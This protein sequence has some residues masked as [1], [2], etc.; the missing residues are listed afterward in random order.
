MQQVLV[1]DNPLSQ[2]G[3]HVAFWPRGKLRQQREHLLAVLD[4][5]QRVVDSH[6]CI[7][8]ASCKAVHKV[9]QADMPRPMNANA[10]LLDQV[11][12]FG[13]CSISAVI[14]Q[15]SAM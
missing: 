9:I 8:L 15:L 1:E 3:G 13:L 5:P 4:D 14:G 6:C 11:S 7:A 12:R 2:H 10:R